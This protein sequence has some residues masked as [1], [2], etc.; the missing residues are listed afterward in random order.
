MRVLIIGSGRMGSA[1][2]ESW[3]IGLPKEYSIHVIEDKLNKRKYIRRKYSNLKIYAKIPKEW[4]GEYIFLAIK[5]Q[6]FEK[7]SEQILKNVKET[8]YII[9]IMAGLKIDFIKKKLKNLSNVI[10]VMPNIATEVSQGMTCAYSKARIKNEKIS[11]L[12]NILRPMG[13]LIWL[14]K[15]SLIDSVTAISGSGPA[16]FFLF[17]QLMIKVS[18]ELGFSKSESAIIVNQT[19]IGAI[20]MIREKRNL[21]KLIDSVVS[22]GGTTEAALKVFLSK[23]NNLEKLIKKGILA[24][25]KKSQHI[26]KGPKYE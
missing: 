2:L 9:S 4:V 19:A 14:K 5:P 16:Y 1:M 25:R 6:D 18:K 13:K 7:T 22:K 12:E 20:E 11:N 26:S 10:R 24:A 23:D 21:E 15:E 17:I 8:K 3:K